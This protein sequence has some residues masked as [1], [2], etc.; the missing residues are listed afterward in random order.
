MHHVLL[1]LRGPP[2]LLVQRF[3]LSL[4][5]VPNEPN[6]RSLSGAVLHLRALL[7]RKDQLHDLPD[8]PHQAVPAAHLPVLP[9][10]LQPAGLLLRLFG[11]NRSIIVAIGLLR[12]P[13]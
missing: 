6:L 5:H 3:A 12:L 4:Q 11:N 1:V 7:V 10:K 13:H 9:L 8:G 2:Q